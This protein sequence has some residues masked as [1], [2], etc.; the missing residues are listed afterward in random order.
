MAFPVAA[1]AIA[2]PAIGNAL[3]SLFGKKSL[4]PEDIQKLFASSMASMTPPGGFGIDMNALTGQLG[5][6]RDQSI[7]GADYA[8]AQG[9]QRAGAVRHAGTAFAPGANRFR[10]FG[11]YFNSLIDATRQNRA[12]IGQQ[13]SDAARNALQLTGLKA[14]VASEPS[15][16][17]A[18]LG[19]L[20]SG[21]GAGAGGHFAGQADTQALME[22]L[23]NP[24]IQK[25]FGGK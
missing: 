4:S 8:T 16:G 13:H 12:L 3:G 10:G 19:S 9:A 6:G 1:A 15:R 21:L 2:A 17:S 18:A 23:R 5:A 25:L 14:G 7:R 24:E 22:L 11:Q 20:F